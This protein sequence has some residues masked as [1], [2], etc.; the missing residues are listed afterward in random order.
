[1]D[2]QLSQHHFLKILLSSIE[3]SWHLCQKSVLKLESVSPPT[4]VLFFQDCFDCQIVSCFLCQIVSCFLAIYSL[5]LK[6]LSCPCSPGEF[7]L[8]SKIQISTTSLW[9][10]LFLPLQNWLLS[11]SSHYFIY[12]SLPKCRNEQTRARRPN[13]VSYL[14]FF[15]F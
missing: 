5:C 6:D 7:Y 3:L 14:F 13:P 1:M 8:S 15:F 10:I 4:F 9:S 12:L 2:I 11:P